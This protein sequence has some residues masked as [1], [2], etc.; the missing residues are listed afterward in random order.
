MCSLI[1]RMRCHC[2][3]GEVVLALGVI[4]IAE[5]HGER[6]LREL[7]LFDRIEDV[8]ALED[9]A[10]AVQAGAGAS[11]KPNSSKIGWPLKR[12]LKW[13]GIAKVSVCGCQRRLLEDADILHQLLD[14]L[15][16]AENRVKAALEPVAVA[17]APRGKHAACDRALLN[18]ERALSRVGQIF[19]GSEPSRAAADDQYIRFRRCDQFIAPGDTIA[20]LPRLS[21]FVK[22]ARALIV[23]LSILAVFATLLAQPK[24]NRDSRHKGS[25]SGIV[26]ESPRQVCSRCVI[27]APSASVGKPARPVGPG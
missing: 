3:V 23:L 6:A 24:C 10:D 18:D 22:V 27:P 15:V 1:P 17:I 20:L 7:E 16:P 21:R 5:Q 14:V 19:R 9:R 2:D 4:V 26:T 13:G 8:L 11:T 25:S 12:E